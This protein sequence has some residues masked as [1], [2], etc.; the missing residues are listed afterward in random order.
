VVTC[1]RCDSY[2]V[3]DDPKRQLCDKCWRDDEI[4]RLARW[5]R[6]LRQDRLAYLESDLR[7]AKREYQRY[8]DMLSAQDVEQLQ[9]QIIKHNTETSAIIENSTK[10]PS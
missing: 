1:N 10:E 8:K 7:I 5:V 9:M 4:A 2:A 6:N 3:N